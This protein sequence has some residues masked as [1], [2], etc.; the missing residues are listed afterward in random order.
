MTPSGWRAMDPE[1]PLYPCS[2]MESRYLPQCYVM[3]TSVMLHLNGGDIRGAAGSCELAPEDMRARCFQSL[4]RD[5]SS[6][7]LRA[8]CYVGLVKNF[9]DLTSETEKAF[10]F[11]RK[12]EGQ[13]NKL[14]CYVAI[15]EQLASLLPERLPRVELCRR[16]ESA[17]YEQACLYGAR[18]ARQR[19]DGI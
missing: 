6:Y 14:R 4:G 15:G 8:W 3:Q 1:D 10:T 19:P 13:V 11:C 5:I 9:I 16:A 2:A 18:V 7:T 17:Q 12:I